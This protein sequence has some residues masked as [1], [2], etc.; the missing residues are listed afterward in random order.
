[1]IVFWTLTGLAS[2]L[3][4]LL[5]L[6]GARR[7]A[8]VD[9][10]VAGGAGPAEAAAELAELDRLKARGLIDED[11]W[12]AARAE[13]GRRILATQGEQ[14][15]VAAAPVARVSDR[16][17]V[18]GGVV[19]AIVG[20][21]GLYVLTGAPGLPD[22][23]YEKRV[24]A[25]GESQEPLAPIQVAA[26]IGRAAKDNPDD[27]RLLTM[28]GAAR[29]QAEDPIGAASA[30]RRALALDPEDAQTWARLGESLVRANDGTI[31]ADAEAAFHEAVKR[32]PGQLGARY[33][34]GEA[35]LRRGDTAQLNAQ[36]R[37]LIA[38]LEPAD[39]RRA[40]LERRLAAAGP[41]VG[42]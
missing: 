16:R 26:V 32:D 38:A 15:A 41:G 31:G 2:A 24:A 29:F 22:Q 13:A 14:G 28:L 7:G 1:M 39:P 33:F 4:G 35:A 12:R 19:V 25:W 6:A 18:L 8:A 37:P 36:W 23:P 34:L 30:F 11:A 17:W 20:A 5:V 10:Q 40:E 9:P 3:A 21:L 42:R 27:R